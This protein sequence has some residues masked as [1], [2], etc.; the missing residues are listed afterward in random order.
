[1]MMMMMM[2]MLLLLLLWF[3]SHILV[4]YIVSHL[5]YAMTNSELHITFDTKC[6]VKQPP[7]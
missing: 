5:Y 2:M 3:G 6:N 4:A 1:M 7:T